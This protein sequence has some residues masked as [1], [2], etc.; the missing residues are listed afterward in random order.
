M[1]IDKKTPKETIGHTNFSQPSDDYM[2]TVDIQG[3]K[4]V[5]QGKIIIDTV[6]YRRKTNRA[7]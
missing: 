4:T 7:L 6:E 2:K 5:S 3:K 1:C